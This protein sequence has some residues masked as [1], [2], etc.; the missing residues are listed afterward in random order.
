MPPFPSALRYLWQ[1]FAR[2]SS[3]RGSTGWGPAPL[4]WQDIDAFCR[5]SGLR[6]APWEIETI[7]ALDRLALSDAGA[8]S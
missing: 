6:F 1:A 4:S 2:M 5:L 3:R 8:K 7:E